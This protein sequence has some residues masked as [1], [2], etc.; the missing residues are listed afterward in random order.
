MPLR[1]SDYS[2]HH[3]ME[4]ILRSRHFYSKASYRHRIKS[5]VEYTIGLL[6][7]L[8]VPRPRVNLHG[9]GHGLHEAGSGAFRPAEREWVGRRNDLDQ[10]QHASG[11][12]QLGDGRRLGQPG[13][14]RVRRLTRSPGLTD[15]G[16]KPDEAARDVRQPLLQDDLAAEARD[17]ILAAGSDRSLAGLRKALQLLLHCPE[18]QLA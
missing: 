13:S 8:E 15:H 4:I 6:R 7:M 18:F 5:P 9:G 10:Q 16:V 12:P 17:L 3:V 1:S 2:I 11:S 14:R